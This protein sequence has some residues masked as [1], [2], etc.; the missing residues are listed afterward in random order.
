MDQIFNILDTAAG[1]Q[2]AALLITLGMAV[3]L[4]WGWWRRELGHTSR[5]TEL[6]AGRVLRE[7]SFMDCINQRDSDLA[8]LA[9]EVF[10]VLQDVSSALGGMERTLDGV[11]ALVHATLNS[12]INE[13]NKG[14]DNDRLR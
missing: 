7:K 1:S 10:G 2:H 11:E 5:F 9:R 8:A 3:A 13:G 14:G 4:A 6:E 12:R